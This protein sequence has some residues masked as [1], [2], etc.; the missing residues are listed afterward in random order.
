MMEAYLIDWLNLLGRWTHMITGIAW[1]GASFYFVW[2]DNHL[3]SPEHSKDIERGVGGEIWSVHGGGFYHAQKYKVAPQALP[4]TLHWFKW[5]A[6]STWLSGI[7]LLALIYWYGAEIYLIDPGVAELSKPVAIAIGMAVIIAGWIVYDLLCKS[8]LGNNDAL[9]GVVMF[10]LLTIAAW[11]LCQVFSGRGAYIHFGAI[12]GTI[13]VA[14]VFFVIIPGQRELVTAKQEGRDADPKHGLMGKQRSVHNT[15]FTLPV[16]FVM[17]SNHYAMTYGHEYNWL[18]LIA[19]SLAG[20]LVRVY[21]VAR[22]FGKP[23]LV[24]AGVAV[25]IM[26]AVV[27]AIMPPATGTA[28]NTAQASAADT[29]L[30]VQNIVHQRCTVCHAASPTQPGFTAPPKGV[31]FDSAQDIVTQAAQIHQQTVVT[32]AMP[33]G[34][35]TQITDDERALLDQWFKAGAPAQ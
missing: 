17:I 25:L 33:I 15:Y 24:P 9:L 7:F 26:A 31:V 22:H 28:M 30:Q 27:T 11:G 4:D 35:L 5:E 16:L 10:V 2:L 19:I 29:F 14:N 12:L 6:Y 3:Q 34:N 13:M 23:S 32:K 20:A 21:F 8:P 18:I 1:I